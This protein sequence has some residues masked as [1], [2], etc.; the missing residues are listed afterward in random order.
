MTWEHVAMI[1][2]LVLINYTSVKIIDRAFER[3]DK[4]KSNS[5]WK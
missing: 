4:K 5:L 2:V 1:T 3:G